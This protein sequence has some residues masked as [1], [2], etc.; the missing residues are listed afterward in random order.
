MQQFHSNPIETKENEIGQ[1]KNC[2][3][4]TYYKTTV[5]ILLFFMT[6]QDFGYA[7]KTN[8]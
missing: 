4:L 7:L 8:C 5:K 1:D 6:L 3:L 2:L